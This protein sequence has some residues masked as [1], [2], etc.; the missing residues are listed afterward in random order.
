[1]T[2]A[3]GSTPQTAAIGAAFADPLAVAVTANNPVEPV[4]GGVVNFVA[5]PRG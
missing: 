1:M 5:E 3:A 2:P 4:D